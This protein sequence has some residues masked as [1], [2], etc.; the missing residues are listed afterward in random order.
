[1]NPFEQIASHVKKTA[2]KLNLNANELEILLTPQHI[3]R[4]LLEVELSFGKKS[5]PAYRVQFNNARGPYKGGIRFHP[6]ADEA[7]VSALAAAMA[8]KCAVVDIPFGGA[9]GGVEIDPKKCTTDDLETISRAYVQAFQPYLGVNIDIPAPD[10]YTNSQVMAWML[11]EYESIIDESVPG[12]ITG[13]P[14]SLGGSL[15]RD[16]ATATGAFFVLDSYLA[17]VGDNL[18]GKKVA[19]QGFGNAGAVVAELLAQAGAT[20]VA[21]ADSSAA[22]FCE[23]GLDVTA[24]TD[25]K[26]SGG[27][28]RD[29]SSKSVT[30][31]S[32]PNAVLEINCD[33]LVPAALDNAITSTNADSIKATVVL[34]LANN[35]TTPEA[36][37][38]LTEKGVVILPDVLVN[39][40][41]VI[42]SYFEWVQNRQQFYWSLEEVESRLRTQITKAFTNIQKE[43]ETTAN[44]CNC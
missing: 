38:L 42:V 31:N 44:S 24:L 39:A 29:Y 23:Q 30:I 41:G 25:Y 18:K 17:S 15:G 43:K 3:R 4:E 28:L 33:V 6:K 9:K 27:A 40:G 13:K 20:I 34:E 14:I 16:T 11:D 26:S 37:D 35:P 19:I 5:L 22:I 12:F 32:D 36:E 1:M 8:I 2:D 10:V 7:E 21:A